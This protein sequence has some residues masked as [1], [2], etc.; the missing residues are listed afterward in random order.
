MRSCD[1]TSKR[2]VRFVDRG[3]RRSRGKRT[4]EQNPDKRG[5]R[6]ERRDALTIKV[7]QL[8]YIADDYS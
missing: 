7:S 6:E 4:K 3:M 5:M 8:F 2:A 1:S